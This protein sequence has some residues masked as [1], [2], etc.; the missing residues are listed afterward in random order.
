LAIEYNGLFWHS[1]YY[2][3]NDYHSLKSN[4]CNKEGIKLFHVWEDDWIY[5][6][7]IVKSIIFK[8]IGNYDKIDANNCKINY[9]DSETA[10]IFLDENHIQ[11][12]DD[13]DIYIGIFNDSLISLMSFKNIKKHSYEIVRYCDI[14]DK[15]IID[16]ND[17][18]L[19]FFIN[20]FNPGEILFKIDRSYSDVDISNN[21]KKIGETVP[22]LYFII[23]DKRVDHVNENKNYNKIYNAGYFNYLYEKNI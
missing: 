23:G 10:R 16:S 2:K 22:S 5:N 14:L 1:D 8:E 13:S 7:N 3:S 9:V 11:G 21:F 4:M 6:K 15:K 12:K 18:L 20:N 17:L 19:N